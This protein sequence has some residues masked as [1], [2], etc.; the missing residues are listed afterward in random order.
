MYEINSPN[1]NKAI[2]KVIKFV[3]MSILTEMHIPIIN[4]MINIKNNL[5]IITPIPIIL[6]NYYFSIL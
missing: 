4:G 1:I 6:L 2:I 5:F 3:F